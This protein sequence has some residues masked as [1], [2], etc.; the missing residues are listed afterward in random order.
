MAH[1]VSRL[2]VTTRSGGNR[3]ESE[4]QHGNN[5]SSHISIPADS[6]RSEHRQGAGARELSFLNST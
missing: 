3:G 5:Q 4:S 1:S 6:N 2:A